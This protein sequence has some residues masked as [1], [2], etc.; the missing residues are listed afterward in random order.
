M[1]DESS[2]SPS[3]IHPD[4]TQAI[5]RLLPGQLIARHVSTL[6]AGD[7]TCAWCNEP[8]SEGQDWMLDVY[9]QNGYSDTVLTVMG[10]PQVFNKTV[11]A[12][13]LP[14]LSHRCLTLSMLN[15]L[16]AFARTGSVK[17]AYHGL[18]TQ[19][20]YQSSTRLYRASIDFQTNGSTDER[21]RNARDC[22][23]SI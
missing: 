9:E 7:T 5:P 11:S 19:G 17:G 14:V 10:K 23:E 20:L 6:T 2:I 8:F 1:Q 12:F 16:D 21:R 4:L 18:P 15:T 13:I 22:V 3:R